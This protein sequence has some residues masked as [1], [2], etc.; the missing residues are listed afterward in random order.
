MSFRSI[1]ALN[2]GGL[3][4]ITGLL[5]EVFFCFCFLSQKLLFFLLVSSLNNSYY[6]FIAVSWLSPQSYISS[7][8]I[9]CMFR[10][11][12]WQG[13]NH[14]LRDQL[15]QPPVTWLP[16]VPQGTLRFQGKHFYVP[17]WLWFSVGCPK[18]M[19]LSR[20]CGE[21]SALPVGRSVFRIKGDVGGNRL[22][23]TSGRSSVILCLFFFFVF[24]Q[25]LEGVLLRHMFIRS[26]VFCVFLSLKLGWNIKFYYTE[27]L[28]AHSD[29]FIMLYKCNDDPIFSIFEI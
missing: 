13:P 9:Q 18:W 10:H 22:S 12:T 15:F 23:G 5:C 1:K 16:L 24:K 3:L 29:L 26:Q 27:L 19:S 11:M 20:L 21:Y 14:H 4:S 28:K 2:L 7:S 8:D 25:M 17:G 6:W